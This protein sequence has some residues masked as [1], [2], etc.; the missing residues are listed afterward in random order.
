MD[1]Q[2][3][4][5]PEAALVTAN[6][7]LDERKRS[8][9]R[10]AFFSEFIDLFDI[11]LPAVIL[12]PVLAFF[13]PAHLS[14]GMEGIMASLVFVTTLLGRPI[15]AVLFGLIADRI[16]RR[17]ASIYSVSGFGILTLLIA[18]LPGYQTIGISSY[19]LLI[20]LRFLD[21]ICLGGGYTG[22]IPLAFEYSR[23]EQRGLVGGII[24]TGFPF[25]FVTINLLAMLTFRIFPLA[26]VDSP[27]AQ[28]GWRI[29]FIVGA[30]LAGVLAYY[31][32][33]K[34]SESELWLTETP[35]NATKLPLRQL[36]RGKN[37][38]SLV[39]VFIMTTGFWLTQDI[40]T[41]FVPSVL[42]FHILHLPKLDVT[43]TLMIAYGC[44]IFSYIAFATL[45]Q[46]IGRRRF[47]M[48]SGP[49][50]A[51]VGT[52]ILYVLLTAGNGLPLPAIIVLVTLLSVIA[53]APWALVITYINERFVTDV[54]ATGFGI[55]FSL[56]VIIPSFY[57]FYM[58]GL[59]HFMPPSITPAVLLF[60]G[61]ILGAI[62]AMIGPETKDVDF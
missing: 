47:F 3:I 46:K 44:M 34:V 19:L 55:G 30:V 1:T 10:G 4:S 39:Q 60:I 15:G 5:P 14:E 38:K 37:A 51:I 40:V 24:M 59:G 61:G 52:T 62:G 48:I 26:G 45:A 36:L 35:A 43:L 41:I 16:G 6:T 53:T 8:A 32:I 18:L 7:P 58:A 29:P 2:I 42:M 54:R 13:Q 17:T 57:A 23:K 49:T 9:I 33:S 21:G 28:W 20:L 31:Y 50:T 22:S 27:Y 12:A 56:S 11:Y 25:A